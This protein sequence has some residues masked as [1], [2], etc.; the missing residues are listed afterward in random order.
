MTKKNNNLIVVLVVL[1]VIILF[2]GGFGYRSYGMMGM[3]NFA[4]SLFNGV[5]SIL[6]LFLLIFGVYWLIKHVNIK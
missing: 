5:F 2:S 1:L 3:P 6:V 4:L